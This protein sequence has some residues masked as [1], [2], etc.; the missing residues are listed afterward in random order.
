M[1]A[2]LYLTF[3]FTFFCFIV[4]IKIPSTLLSQIRSYASWKLLLYYI[5]MFSFLKEDMTNMTIVIHIF[6]HS[7]LENRHYYYD[8][9]QY[10]CH[11]SKHMSQM[12]VAKFLIIDSYWALCIYI[13]SS[14]PTANGSPQFR[15]IYIL[16]KK[17]ELCY[18]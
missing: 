12:R 9:A 2:I 1:D 16:Q 15:L 5:F 10:F 13:P 6:Q 11:V 18:T 3:A 17:W 7:L 8:C 14:H 4:I